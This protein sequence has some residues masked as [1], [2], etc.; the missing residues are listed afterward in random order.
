MD[1][2]WAQNTSSWNKERVP[3]FKDFP[4]STIYKG[5]PAKVK[6]SS[7][8]TR[9]FRTQLRRQAREGPNF[10]SHYTV[11]EWG[12]GSN[13]QTHMIINAKT[14]AV[15]QCVGT[16]RGIEV[17][18]DSKLLIADPP[19][20]GSGLAYADNPTD[21]LPVRYYVWNDNSL[22]LIY[23]EPCIVIDRKQICGRA[24]NEKKP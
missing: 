4:V 2:I 5:I 12:C 11:A 7:P 21:K 18:L 19:D 13:C 22:G 14:G 1:E 8:D 23:E 6:L 9:M 15:H 10:A 3:E 17:R 24:S 16:E 20:G